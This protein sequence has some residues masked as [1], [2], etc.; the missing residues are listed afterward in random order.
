MIKDSDPLFVL[1]LSSCTVRSASHDTNRVTDASDIFLY[2]DHMNLSSCMSVTAENENAF[3]SYLTHTVYDVVYT[4]KI[5]ILVAVY[6][7][8]ESSPTE[9][10]ST[11]CLQS[12]T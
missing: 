8:I 9:L 3:C 11:C 12:S 2:N 5:Q 10:T 1:L 6:G 4:L 7:N